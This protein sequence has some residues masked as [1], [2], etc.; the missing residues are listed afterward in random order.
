MGDD[1]ISSKSSSG[2]RSSIWSLYKGE[3]NPIDSYSKDFSLWEITSNVGEGYDDTLQA[4]EFSQ[5]RQNKGN[6]EKVIL[7][8]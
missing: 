1:I 8:H 5:L 3:V 7:R 4:F 2:K 6:P